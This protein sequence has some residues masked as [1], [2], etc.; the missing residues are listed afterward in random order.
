MGVETTGVV[1]DVATV[2]RECAL[3]VLPSRQE[4]FGIAVAEAL[5]C[6]VP[7]IVTPSGGPEELV[8]SSGGGHVTAGWS[9]RE[10]ADA[11]LGLLGD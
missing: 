3:F 4:G 11:I 5:A 6:G 2:L 8:R 7:A 9:E 1:P 10:L